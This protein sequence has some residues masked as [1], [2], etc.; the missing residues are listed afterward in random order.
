M[1]SALTASIL[2]ARATGDDQPTP[3][4]YTMVLWISGAICVVAA[5]LAW[6]LPTRSSQL[7]PAER[8]PAEELRLLEQ[9]DGDGLIADSTQT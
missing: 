7:A 8:L 4:G 5:A 3:G 1:G 2:A 6:F 9:T